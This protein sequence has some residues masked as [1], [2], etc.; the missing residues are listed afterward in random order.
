MKEY[1]QGAVG[2]LMDEYERVV[3]EL[4]HVVETLSDDEYQQVRDTVTTDE[5]CR[6]FRTILTHVIGAGYGYAGMMR[7]FWGVE[8]V[9][10]PD[11]VPTAAAALDGL[12]SILA[13]MSETLDGH[14]DLSEEDS[15]AMKMPARWGPVYDFEQLFEH[16][17]VHVMRHRRQVERFLARDRATS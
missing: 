11:D 16:A 13:Y 4:A 9:G 1:R 12:Q 10:R 8:R 14:W 6:S 17:I 3:G 2:A 7:D 15:N 5:A